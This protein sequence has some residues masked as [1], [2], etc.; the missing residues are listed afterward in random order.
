M[1][2]TIWGYEVIKMTAKYENLKSNH[3][4]A[5][6]FFW[7]GSGTG[8][9]GSAGNLR[10]GVLGADSDGAATGI[11]YHTVNGVWVSTTATIANFYGA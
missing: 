10:N 8:S 3:P 1:R 2:V 11:V 7:A 5:I 6:S 4:S 9:A